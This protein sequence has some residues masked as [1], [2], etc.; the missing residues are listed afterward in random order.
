MIFPHFLLCCKTKKSTVA[1]KTRKNFVL[2]KVEETNKIG[3]H[4][5]WWK[6]LL[7]VTY[8]CFSQIN[9]E[10]R[11]NLC[12][13]FRWLQ[14]SIYFHVKIYIWTFQPMLLPAQVLFRLFLWYKIIELHAIVLTNGLQIVFVSA[15]E[16]FITGQQETLLASRRWSTC[17][18]YFSSFLNLFKYVLYGITVL[19]FA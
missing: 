4:F 12:A 10:Q 11:K 2:I 8:V 19:W 16:A 9:T 7:K 1:N 14:V 6:K 18:L 3:F 15:E 13:R 5:I 17:F